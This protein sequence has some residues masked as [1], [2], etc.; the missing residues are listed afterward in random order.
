MAKYGNKKMSYGNKANTGDSHGTI[1]SAS[2]GGGTD[3]PNKMTGGSVQSGLSGKS[4]MGNYAKGD[5]QNANMPRQP[6]DP[7]YQVTG[8]G[9]TFTVC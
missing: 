4:P 8:N 9:E 5:A 1:H 2:G 6:A 3:G 7:N